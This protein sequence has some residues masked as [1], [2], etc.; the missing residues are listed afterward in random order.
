MFLKELKAHPLKANKDG[1][2]IAE[3]AATTNMGEENV[4]IESEEISHRQEKQGSSPPHTQL[5]ATTAEGTSTGRSKIEF[6][7]SAQVMGRSM[8]SQPLLQ[9]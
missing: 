8:S 7:W 5:V 3:V 4:T 1:G 2:Q 6:E 9:C